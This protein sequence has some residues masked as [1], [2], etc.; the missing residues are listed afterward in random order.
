MMPPFILLNPNYGK[1]EEQGKKK[2]A[3]K[4]C[5]LNIRIVDIGAVTSI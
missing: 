4:R 2:N 1:K 3:S 5:V